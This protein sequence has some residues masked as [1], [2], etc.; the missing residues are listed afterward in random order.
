MLGIRIAEIH[1]DGIT[2]EMEVTPELYNF[3]GVLHGGASA[4]L[5]DAAMGIAITHHYPGNKTA[6]VEL[7][8]N[9]MRPVSNGKVLARAR[10]IKTGRTL[11]V[12]EVI[13]V[14]DD[15]AEVARALMTYILLPGTAD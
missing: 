11:I 10:F 1:D 4:S 3:Y 8:I 2:V 15:G 6:T 9:Y 7:K 13:A 14:R 5:V 12:G